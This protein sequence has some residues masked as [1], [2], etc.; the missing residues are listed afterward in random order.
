MS[1]G[2]PTWQKPSV[3]FQPRVHTSIQSGVNQIVEA[4]GPTLGPTPRI[5][6]YDTTIGT[7]GRLPEMLD[8][9]GIIARRILGISNRD[10]DVGAM[11]LRHM[12]W[13]QHEDVGDGTATAAVL[14][15]AVYN[16]GVRYIA[17]EGNAMRLRVH[18]EK[19]LRVILNELAK[20]RRH[21]QGKAALARL[22]E[23]ICYN[24]ELAKLLGEIFDIIGE[25]GR[26]ELRSSQSREMER[27]YVEGMYWDSGILSRSMITDQA[28]QRAALEN[29]AILITNFDIEDPRDL[30]PAI[31]TVVTQKMDGLVVVARKL[32]QTVMG[33]IAINQKQQRIKATIVGAKTPGIAIGDQRDAVADMAILTGG[34]PFMDVS[35]EKLKNLKPGDLGQARRVWVDK[36]HV[37]IIGGKGDPRELRRH[38]AGLRAAYAQAT[39][40]QDRQALQKRIGKLMGGSATLWVGGSTKPEIDFNKELAKRT[41][42]AMRGAIREGVVPGGGVALLDCRPALERCLA[43]AEEPEERAAYRILLQAVEAPIRT[44]LN[45]AGIEPGSIFAEI[46]N[47]GPGY[48]LDVRT[49]K[50]VDMA[51][52][53]IFDPASV[54][55]TSASNAIRTAAL[56]LTTDVIVHRRNPPES[57]ETD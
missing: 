46:N 11:L 51:E 14:F 52:T 44:L 7:T 1:K 2:K 41:A 20:M 4:I 45:N 9:G 5:V 38:I 31:T 49:G 56:A 40:P 32:S 24:T 34:H 30:I 3:V 13:R 28:R 29:P 8:N 42:D 6:L 22:A 36:N 26:L 35:G 48:G 21:L 57:F 12:L 17:A 16:E 25:H 10:A 39:A 55:S 15:Q 27:E 53:G 47:A 37:G 19:G 33:F 50:V 54:V 18:L 23:T 43:Q